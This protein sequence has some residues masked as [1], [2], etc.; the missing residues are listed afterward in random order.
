MFV[1]VLLIE[2]F[3]FFYQEQKLIYK[4]KRI[5]WKVPLDLRTYFNV[6]VRP[7]PIEHRRIK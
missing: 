7:T 2:F 3:Y 6:C 1:K 4:K 5:D